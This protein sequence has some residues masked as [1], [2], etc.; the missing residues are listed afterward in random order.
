RMS[1]LGALH[2]SDL[3][4]A[5]LK[6]VICRFEDAWFRGERPV[7]EDFLPEN[8]SLRNIALRELVHIDLELRRKAGERPQGDDYFP[9]FPEL[10]TDTGVLQSLLRTSGRFHA[11]QEM[12]VV[13]VPLGMGKEALMTEYVPAPD[14][15][16]KQFG[17]YSILRKLG[18]GGM[19]AVYLALD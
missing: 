8:V 3:Q 4:W 17:R 10:A 13:R 12:P 7:I 9:R 14:G 1:E 2:L 5:A 6:P 15:L 19:G 11:S 16:P 18:S